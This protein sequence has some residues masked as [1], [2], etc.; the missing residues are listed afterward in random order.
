M[1]LKRMEK[2]MEMHKGMAINK[3]LFSRE[4]LLSLNFKVNISGR[5]INEK[6]AIPKTSEIPAKGRCKNFKTAP[7]N[8]DIADI[9]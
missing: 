4:C 2:I 9:R 5:K 6:M 8:I 7:E 1:I 3:M